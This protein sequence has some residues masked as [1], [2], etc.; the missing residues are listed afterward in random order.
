[1][2]E[3]EPMTKKSSR[4]E[5]DGTKNVLTN[6]PNNQAYPEKSSAKTYSR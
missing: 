1:M 2:H 3:I 6:S 4:K 5:F